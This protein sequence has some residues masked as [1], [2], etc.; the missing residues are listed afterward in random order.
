[1]LLREDIENKKFTYW[2]SS[3]A[4]VTNKRDDRDD[5]LALGRKHIGAKN[6]FE[7][8]LLLSYDSNGYLTITDYF[9]NP[10]HY[11]EYYINYIQV[12]NTGELDDVIEKSGFTIYE[13]DLDKLKTEYP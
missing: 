10:L 5:Y 6:E 2:R 8:V 9:N 11:R 1:M 13:I 3:E 12:D 4:S 7:K